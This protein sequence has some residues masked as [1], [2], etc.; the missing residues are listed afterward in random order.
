M[1]GLYRQ[2]IVSLCLVLPLVLVAC[3]QPPG[4]DFTTLNSRFTDQ[5]PVLSGDGKLLAFISDRSGRQELVLYDLE[6]RQFLPLPGL[7]QGNAVVESPSLSRT[8]RYIVY[9]SSRRGRPEIE[10]Y[11]RFSR[12]IQTLTVGYQGWIRY[13][14][15]DPDGR[16]ITFES[17]RRGQ[18]DIEIF[19]RGQGVELDLAPGANI[20]PPVP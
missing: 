5:Q 3:S 9:L 11:D 20:R 15:I 2:I 7:N 18:W 10:L 17:G 1:K 14:R 12:N 16:Y 13:P 19:D 4:G 8:G 6:Q